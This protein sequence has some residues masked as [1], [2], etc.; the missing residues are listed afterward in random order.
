LFTCVVVIRF[1]LL[2]AQ[3]AHT[4]DTNT[5]SPKHVTLRPEYTK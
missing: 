1:D 3:F 4:I 2:H 5:H